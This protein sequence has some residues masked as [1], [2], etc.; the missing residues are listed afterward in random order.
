MKEEISFD[1]IVR[2][3][4][5]TRKNKRYGRDSVDFEYRWAQELVRMFDA[6]RQRTFSVEHNYAFLTSYPKW[7]EIF[8]TIFQGRIDDRTC[9]AQGESYTHT[10]TPFCFIIAIRIPQKIFW[11]F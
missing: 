2:V 4:L 6:L 7:R 8:A 10:Y 11:T 9:C 1:L 3:M 5:E